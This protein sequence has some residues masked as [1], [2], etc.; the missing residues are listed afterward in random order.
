MVCD[1]FVRFGFRLVWT[2]LVSRKMWCHR[3]FHIV[4]LAV[5]TSSIKSYEVTFLFPFY[6][7][8]S[9]MKYVTNHCSR[10]A[11]CIKKIDWVHFQMQ[12]YISRIRLAT[13]DTNDVDESQIYIHLFWI[14]SKSIF[15]TIFIVFMSLVLFSCLVCGLWTNSPLP[16]LNLVWSIVDF[17]LNP[18]L[19]RTYSFHFAPDSHLPIQ[20]V[21][22]VWL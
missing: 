15:V 4:P 14:Y 21:W 10:Y 8:F 16:V 7:N 19:S 12:L 3:R 9:Q 11:R 5:F 6:F 13:D 22:F 18:F 17:A 2:S 1:N 20:F